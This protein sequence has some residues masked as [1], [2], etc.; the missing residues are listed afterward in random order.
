M[1]YMYLVKSTMSGRISI[2]PS[3]GEIE[4][5]VV[6]K[7]VAEL[8]NRDPRTLPALPGRIIL[9]NGN[10]LAKSYS[11]EVYYQIIKTGNGWQCG[12]RAGQYGRLCKHIKGLEGYLAGEQARQDKAAQLLIQKPIGTQAQAYQ[13]RKRAAIQ[14]ARANPSPVDLAVCNLK[15]MA[16]LE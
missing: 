7:L 12:C 14:A 16:V 9:E 5:E 10:A 13:R 4:L 1:Y 11:G 6:Q 2:T 15:P 8:E 3:Q